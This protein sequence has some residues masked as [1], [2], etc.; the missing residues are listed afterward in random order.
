MT[1]DTSGASGSSVELRPRHH[2]FFY[3]VIVIVAISVA[4]V[5]PMSLFTNS[6]GQP[7]VANSSGRSKASTREII[8]QFFVLGIRILRS[9]AAADRLLWILEPCLMRTE[10]GQTYSVLYQ[11]FLHSCTVELVA[12]LTARTLMVDSDGCSSTKGS[13]LSSI[14]AAWVISSGRSRLASRLGRKLAEHDPG[15]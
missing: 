7:L 4:I 11:G 3:S 14:K 12:V 6:F 1:C 13:V 8:L 2:D 15:N 5:W 10:R 9:L